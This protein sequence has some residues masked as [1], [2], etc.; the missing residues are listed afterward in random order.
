M[1]NSRNDE[2]EK[3][4]TVSQINDISML[5]Y[6]YQFTF[7]NQSADEHQ[8]ICIYRGKSDIIIDNKC[9]SLTE[10]NMVIVPPESS[11]I[12]KIGKNDNPALLMISFNCDSTELSSISGRTIYLSADN[13]AA[14]NEILLA[15]KNFINSSSSTYQYYDM[16]PHNHTSTLRRQILFNKLELFLLNFIDS[17][18]TMTE[19]V[20]NPYRTFSK[21]KL[22]TDI[23]DYLQE[24]ISKNI[25]INELSAQFNMSR[26]H[27]SNIYHN[28]VGKSLIQSFNEM[29][30]NQAKEYI[31][32]T[33]YNISQI[34]DKLGFSS[35]H[36]FSRL[37]KKIVGVS[38]TKYE[39]N[40]YNRGNK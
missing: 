29:K 14:L 13:V 10:S 16:S 33:Q 24:N 17:E 18:D 11:Y 8:L 25:T 6:P 28:E 38:P 21:Q 1:E 37:F 26:S 36:Y 34:S 19:S 12:V 9:F 23:N 3:I 27:I 15:G 20:V 40:I 31:E 32:K 4:L 22:V 7:E 2:K 5:E 30:I 39:Q 35:V